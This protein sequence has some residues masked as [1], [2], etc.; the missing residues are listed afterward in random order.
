MLSVPTNVPNAEVAE[1]HD[2]CFESE[3]GNG[4]GSESDSGC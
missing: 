2:D 3:S 4:S 1:I